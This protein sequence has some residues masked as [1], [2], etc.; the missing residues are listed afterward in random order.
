MTLIALK[1]PQCGGE[2]QLDNVKEIGFCMY[3]G[4]KVV[5]QEALSHQ[6]RIDE[7][8]K[9]DAWITLAYDN[10]RS[11]NYIDAEQYANKII[12]VDLKSPDAWYVKG[13]CAIREQIAVENWRTA[14][15]YSTK[16]TP[17]WMNINKALTDPKNHFQTRMKTV[18]FTRG[19][20]LGGSARRFHI[21]LNDQERLA[22]GNGETQSI[23][24]EEGSYILK[25]QIAGFKA[26]VPLDVKKDMNVYINL[27]KRD[28][29]WD[30]ISS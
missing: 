4:S 12:E 14:L 10:L 3:C 23:K 13:C 22:L 9:K 30:I 26:I 24:I 7:S 21:S 15:N 16:D 5:L 18:T 27:N 2:I 17:L 29:K 6:V 25:G 1:C 11:R 20:A 19:K 8:H 28:N